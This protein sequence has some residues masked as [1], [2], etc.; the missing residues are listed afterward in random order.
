MGWRRKPR[1]SPVDVEGG[2]TKTVIRLRH[3]QAESRNLRTLA[4]DPDVVAA[5][6]ERTRRRI[7]A[8]MWW[9][10]AAGLVFTTAGVHEFI[11]GD[12]EITDPLWWAAWFVEP[13]VA[14]ILILLLNWESEILSRGIEPDSDQTTNLK[15]FLLFC[16]FFMNVYPPLFGGDGIDFGMLFIKGMVPVIVF[17]LAEAMPVV[18]R[19]MRQAISDCYATARMHT[20][21]P[22]PN[23]AP[24]PEPVVEEETVTPVPPEDPVPHPV[25][26]D[27]G[28]AV[29]G[30]RLP[31][32]VIPAL[33]TAADAA[34]AE[35]R[36]VTVEDIRT[37][38]RVPVPIAER[39]TA[40]LHPVNGHQLNA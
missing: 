24:T 32:S 35:S 7:T 29:R 36:P 14:G 3:R 23:P 6:L 12:R 1:V 22:D 5:R 33:Q 4:D 9:F 20:P 37:A 38:V 19:R 21:E 8:G 28:A 10:L 26:I 18:Q 25:S 27:V 34:A 2:V 16:T 15:R 11:A 39:I 30:L 17:L 13:M 31:D 40:A